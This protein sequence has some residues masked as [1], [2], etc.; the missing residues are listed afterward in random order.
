MGKKYLPQLKNFKNST[1]ILTKMQKRGVVKRQNCSC[2]VNEIYCIFFEMA[3]LTK[4]N[5]KLNNLL[6]LSKKSLG[7]RIDIVYLFLSLNYNVN[8]DK[9]G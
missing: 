1:K 3:V 5:I 2:K 6:F 9:M 4:F 8:L 7:A